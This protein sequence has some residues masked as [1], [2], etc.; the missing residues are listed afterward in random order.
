M[1]R[2]SVCQCVMVI[3]KFA[4]EK[5]MSFFFDECTL[6]VGLGCVKPAFVTARAK[7]SNPGWGHSQAGSY[8]L[9]KMF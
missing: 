1:Y 5:A 3:L 9:K 6:A 8:F 2:V 7:P 4:N